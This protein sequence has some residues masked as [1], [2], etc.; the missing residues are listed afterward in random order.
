MYEFK[1][2]PKNDLDRIEVTIE[3]AKNMVSAQ[4]SLERLRKNKDFKKVF[5]KMYLEDEAARLTS[6]L[7]AP[8]FASEEAQADLLNQLRSISMVGQ[9]M[10]ILNQTG[11]IAKESLSDYEQT[12][13][14]LLEEGLA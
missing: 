2:A 8:N 11:I 1:A 14:E 13:E 12:R 5:L 4:E 9:Y 10:Q 6:C 7:S 3:D